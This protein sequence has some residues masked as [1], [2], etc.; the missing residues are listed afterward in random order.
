M[1]FR[2]I[3]SLPSLF[4]W[5]SHMKSQVASFSP[6]LFPQLD[7]NNANSFQATKTHG[8]AA[9]EAFCRRQQST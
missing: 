5:V 4:G 9:G 3:G 1:V 8:V 6:L 2:L 7:A